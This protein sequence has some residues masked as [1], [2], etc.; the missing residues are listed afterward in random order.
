MTIT[1][2]IY[3]LIA[4]ILGVALYLLVTTALDIGRTRSSDRE[5]ALRKVNGNAPGKASRQIRKWRRR[6]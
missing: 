1:H 4:A 6:P 3:G 5:R 2:V